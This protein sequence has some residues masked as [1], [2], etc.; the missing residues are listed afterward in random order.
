MSDEKKCPYCAE[1]I[2]SEAIK[3][4]YCGSDLTRDP[5]QGPDA[6]LP[7]A[8]PPSAVS[9]T[10]CNVALVP[11]QKKRAVSVSGLLSVIVVIAGLITVFGNVVVGILVMILGLIIGAVGG[12]KKTVMVCPKCGTEGP[13]L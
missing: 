8:G 6:T 1:T 4:R 3:C 12:G 9:C 2:R 5:A 11:V 10:T 13:T 7:E